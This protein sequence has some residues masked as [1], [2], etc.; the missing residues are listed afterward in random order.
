MGSVYDV[1]GNSLVASG[2]IGT[3]NS[4]N[5][6][7]VKVNQAFSNDTDTTQNVQD[8]ETYANVQCV[9]KLP[10]TYSVDGDPTPVIMCAH[11]TSGWVSGNAYQSQLN[12]WDDLLAEG[13]ATFDVNGGMPFDSENAHTAGQCMGGPRAVEA[14]FKAFEYIRQKMNVEP[15]LYVSGM[16]MGGLAALNFANRYPEIVKCIGLCYPVTAL[17][18]QAWLHPWYSGTG[19]ATT[20]GCIAREYNFASASTWEAAK[21]VGFNPETNKRIT[22]NSEDYCLLSSPLKIW[23]GDADTTVNYSYSV[24]LVD[25]IKRAGGVAE[26]R[27]VHGAG[28]GESTFSEWRVL[29][30]GELKA[31]FNRYRLKT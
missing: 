12:R 26:M 4:V 28:H 23:H 3:P 8:S 16:S 20:K 9:V 18:N 7:S 31:F 24:A 30:N 17:Y 27:V 10:S 11:G 19:E 6:F 21:V 13:Y 29:F 2:K 15:L 5:Y 25:A 14:Y 1:N 22:V